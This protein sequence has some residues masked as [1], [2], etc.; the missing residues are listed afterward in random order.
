M[1]TLLGTWQ[2]DEMQLCGEYMDGEGAGVL[3]GMNAMEHV[4]AVLGV[5]I[6]YVAISIVYLIARQEINVLR[7]IAKF[8]ERCGAAAE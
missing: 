8:T 3:P 5:G 2:H 7:A 4:D 6:V 1:R